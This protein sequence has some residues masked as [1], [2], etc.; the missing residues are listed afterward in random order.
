MG[1]TELSGYGEGAE[2]PGAAGVSFTG[3]TV[4]LVWSKSA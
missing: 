3:C 1:R 2:L 4:S